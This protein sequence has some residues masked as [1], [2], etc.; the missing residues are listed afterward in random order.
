MTTKSRLC[1]VAICVLGWAGPL[2]A[3]SPEVP[4]RAPAGTTPGAD[5]DAG[6]VSTQFGAWL[7]DASVSERGSGRVSIGAGYWRTT[8]GF[9][10]DVPMFEASYSVTSR[11]QL[12]AFV[13]FYRASIGGETASG[14]DDVY[15]ST[16]IALVNAAAAGRRFGLAVSPAVEIL[17]ENAP[18]ANRVHWTLPVSIEAR[19]NRFRVMASGGYFSRGAVFGGAAVEWTAP[20]GTVVWGALTESRS[21]KAGTSLSRPAQPRD[22][23]D[24]AAGVAQWLTGPVSAYVSVGRTLTSLT[25]GGASLGVNAGVSVHFSPAVPLP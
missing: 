4:S 12:A 1:V 7:D 8:G 22:R 21:V 11:I 2:T 13:P 10:T 17:A 25:A 23:V 19:T 20:S 18:S 9:Q 6:D 3:Q 5:P 15:L 24:V 16:K 14:V